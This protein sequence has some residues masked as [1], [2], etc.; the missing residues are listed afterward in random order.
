MLIN[1]LVNNHSR[2]NNFFKANYLNKLLN[3]QLKDLL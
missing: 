3:L 2:L 1:S